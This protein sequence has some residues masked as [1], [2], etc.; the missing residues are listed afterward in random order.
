MYTKRLLL[1]PQSA[2]ADMLA[3]EALDEMKD[4]TSAIE[5]FQAAVRADPRMPELIWLGYLLWC[6][7]QF[8]EAA[9]EFQAELTINPRHAQALT[10]LGYFETNLGRSEAAMPI[11]EQA[12]SIDPK[13]S[14]ARPP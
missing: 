10:Y 3:G 6:Q 1:N 14:L 5:Q 2:E 11:L 4:R 9:R 7:L 13:D 12:V 8:E